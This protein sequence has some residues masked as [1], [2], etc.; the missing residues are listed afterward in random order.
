MYGFEVGEL[1]PND[2]MCYLYHS[3]KVLVLRSCAAGIL[4]S[5]AVAEDA[6][7]GTDIYH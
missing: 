6:V 3:V 2:L 4:H 5:D 7:D 1:Q